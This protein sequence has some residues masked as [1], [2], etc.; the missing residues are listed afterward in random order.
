MKQQPSNLKFRKYHKPNSN[1]LKLYNH[2]F[3]FLKKGNFGLKSL[4]GGRLKFNEIE[5]ARRTI[6][7]NVGK[8][9]ALWINLFTGSSITK[10]PVAVRMGKG[11]GAHAFWVCAVRKGQ[12]LFE[13]AGLPAADAVSALNKAKTKLSVKTKV[14]R[15]VY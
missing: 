7:R 3:F 5:A 11:K 1:F 10:K 9:T 2:K 12:V 14:I 13:V 15:L 8:E 6:R 4:A